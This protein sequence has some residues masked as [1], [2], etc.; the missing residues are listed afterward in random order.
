MQP[1]RGYIL[2]IPYRL[3]S[4][5]RLPGVR[6]STPNVNGISVR[7]LILKIPCHEFI[8][9]L[10]IGVGLDLEDFFIGSLLFS[11]KSKQ[12]GSVQLDSDFRG[13]LADCLL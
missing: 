1:V 12:K 2:K 11:A 9:L 4:R 10:L 8:V 5:D 7:G 13:F 6:Y 3:D